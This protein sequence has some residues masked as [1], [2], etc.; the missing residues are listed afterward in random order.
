MSPSNLVSTSSVGLSRLIEHSRHL[1][2]D[3]SLCR[4]RPRPILPMGREEET[5]NLQVRRD[6]SD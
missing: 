5:C 4:L 2:V 6:S 1:Y 3:F